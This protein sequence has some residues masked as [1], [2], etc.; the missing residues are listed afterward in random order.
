[1]SRLEQLLRFVKEEPG[2]PFNLYAVA[3]EYLKLDSEKAVP[4]F[5]SLVKDHPHYLPTYY[6]FGKLMQQRKD[7][8][9]ARSLL[10]KGIEIANSSRDVKAAGELRNALAE[11]E[12]ELD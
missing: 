12:F 6:T 9:V 8:D 2:D 3:M 10:E 11:L 1:M 7:F 5:E 4:F